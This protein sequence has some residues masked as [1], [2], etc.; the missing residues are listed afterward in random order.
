MSACGCRESCRRVV[1]R[2][3]QFLRERVSARRRCRSILEK[4]ERGLRT[5][6]TLELREWE[7]SVAESR[8]KT[9]NAQS[10]AEPVEES[11]WDCHQGKMYGCGQDPCIFLNRP[12]ST[13]VLR[14]SKTWVTSPSVKVIFMDS[15]SLSQ[16]PK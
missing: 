2:V 15:H 12:H 11:K 3:A 4:S 7:E 16:S 9:S 13:L 10:T 5:Y 6:A 8:R 14:S 1:Q